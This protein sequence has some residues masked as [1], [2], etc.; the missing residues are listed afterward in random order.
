MTPKR[1]KEIEKNPTIKL[2]KEELEAGWFFC[3]YE[4]DGMLLKKGWAEAEICKNSCNCG[5][6][7]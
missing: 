2:T 5:N 1:Y 7:L 6:Q 3:N 4:W